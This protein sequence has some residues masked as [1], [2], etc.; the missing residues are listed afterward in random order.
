VIPKKYFCR[1]IRFNYTGETDV[2]GAAGYKYKLQ[3]D[4]VSNKSYVPENECFNPQPVEDMVIFFELFFKLF[5]SNIFQ[6][7]F[8]L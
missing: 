1:S 5:F 3:E 6:H 7:F 8:E 2:S 4:L